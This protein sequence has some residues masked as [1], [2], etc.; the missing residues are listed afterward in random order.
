MCV[1]L[2]SQSHVRSASQEFVGWG[3]V[4]YW[5]TLS[6]RTV[7]SPS[8]WPISW[9]V[10]WTQFLVYYWKHLW[11]P[12]FEVLAST[13][14]DSALQHLSDIISFT[15]NFFL[16]LGMT[17][18][19]KFVLLAWSSRSLHRESV[20]FLVFIQ[21]MG[22]RFAAAHVFKSL[23]KVFRHGHMIGLECQ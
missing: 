11:N 1:P 6:H 4:T 13:A 18:E 14:Y 10:R 8:E 3:S 21:Q 15:C 20:L 23:V 12:C 2:W 7:L 22:H 17:L 16:W 9:F 5:H 19:R